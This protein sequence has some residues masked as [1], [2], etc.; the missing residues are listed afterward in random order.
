LEKQPNSRMCFV[1]GIENPIGLHLHFYTDDEGRCITRFQPEPEHQGFP[2]QLHGGIIS[3][4]LD[5]TMGRVLTTR[6]VWVITG[7]LEIKFS[8]PVPLDQELKIIGELTRNRSRAYEARGEIQ[9]P[10][11]TTL[12]EGS[13]MYIRIPDETVE[14]AKS[15]L[16]FWQV[17]PD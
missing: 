10:D 12:I 17:V 5:E 7:R 3:T 1:C 8:K 14:Q 13:G 15:E 6:D 16:D 4:L 9:L 11:G 2:G